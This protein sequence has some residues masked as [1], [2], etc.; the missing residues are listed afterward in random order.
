[1]LLKVPF[2]PLKNPSI[3]ITKRT[4]PETLAAAWPNA[5]V[6]Y[7]DSDTGL[8]EDSFIARACGKNIL[9]TQVTDKL[10]RPVLDAISNKDAP[11]LIAQLAVGYDNID[12]AAATDLGILVTNTPGVVTESTAD[13]AFGL[14][15][16]A[17]R[18]IAEGHQYIHA[19]QWHRWT[20]GL[21]IGRDVHNRTLGILGM[22]QI[23]Q[24]MARRAAGF[25]MRVIYHNRKPVDGSNAEWVSKDD[26]LRESDFLSI[27]VP[28]SAA[29]RHI[30]GEAELRAMKPDAILI[31]TSRGPVVDEPAL[32][33]ALGEKWIAG[34]GL[35][36]FEDEPRVHS[37]I[38]A[39]PSAVVTPHIGGASRETREK[40]VQMVRANVNAFIEGRRPPNLL[41]PDLWR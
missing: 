3:F 2:S 31:N 14:L 34:A 30:I 39:C 32:A 18:R 37:G 17:A 10:S 9:I 13:L 29:T 11:Q 35:D 27:H 40:M 7:H 8:P 15:L 16:A 12:L 26:L 4:F 38:L 24:A 28:L 19:G 33:R 36:V 22:G 25:G 21:M 41:N 6:D 20:M 23:G 5:A 1:M